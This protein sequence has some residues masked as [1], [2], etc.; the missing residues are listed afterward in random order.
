[1]C[2]E[3]LHS[4]MLRWEKEMVDKLRKL[5]GLEPNLVNVFIQPTHLEEDAKVI[6]MP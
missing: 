2:I 5:L 3:V 4:A 6:L 1:M